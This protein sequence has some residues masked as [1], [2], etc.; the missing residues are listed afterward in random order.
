MSVKPPRNAQRLLLSFLRSD[1]AEEVQGDLEERFYLILKKKSPWRAK[2]NYW[3]QVINYL[4]PFAIRK[5]RLNY[6]NHYDMFQNYFK[7]GFRNLLRNKG[8]SIINIGGLA[9]GMMIAMLIGLWIYDELTYDKYHENYE[10][11]A[12]V[13]Q[14]Q[15]FNGSIYSDYSLPRPLESVLRNEFASD[16]KY[17]SMSSWTGDHI[18]SFGEEKI[19][20]TGNFVQADFP[21]MFSLKMLQGTYKGFQDPTAI[22]LSASTAKALFGNSD[23]LNQSMRIDNRMDVKVVGV[24]QDIPYNSSGN[25]FH[26]LA[27]WDLYANTDDWIKRAV[28][29]WGNNSFQ[30]FVQIAPNATMEGISEKIKNVKRDH[31]K[32]EAAFKPEIY[33][34]PM[35]DW[36]LRS[37]WKEG[38]KTGGRIEMVWLFGIIGIFVLLLACINFM[39]L[40]T[41]RS[42]KRAK[43]VGIR[44]TVGSLRR[45]LINQFLSESFLVVLLA[46]VLTIIFVAL[47]LPAFNNLAD[48]RISIAWLS[49]E[50]WLISILFITVTSL[51]AGSYPAL[52]LSSF[53]PVKVLKGTFKTGRLASIPRKILVVIQFK[54]SVILIIGTIIVYQQIEYTKNRPIGYNRDQLIMMEMK[55][56]EYMGKFDVLKNELKSVGAIEE[57]AESSS[58]ITGVWSNNGGFDWEGKDPALQTDFATIWITHDYGKTV[59]WQLVNGRDMS[60]EFA[61]DSSAIILNEAALKFMNVKE[62]VGM[63]IKWNSRKYHVIG[64]VKDMIMQSPYEPV[65]Q[66]VYV[67]HY[68]NVSWI[69]IKL[70]PEKSA[71]ESLALIESV[72]KKHIP[73]A[74]FEYKFV[75]DEYAKKFDGEVRIGKL[76]LIFAVLAIFISCLGIFGLASFVAEQRTKEIGIRKVMGASVGSLWRMLSKEFV[77]LVIISCAIA[78]P[79][80]YYLLLNWLDKYK[81]HTEISWWII[82]VTGIGTLIITLITVSFQAIKAALMSPVK[83]LKSE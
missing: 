82:V 5:S 53:Q 16:F 20:K 33:L 39:N 65:K 32:D 25:E 62:P 24:Y 26:F 41:A 49:A 18:L 14:H 60:R 31:S 12:Q 10:H 1:L 83:S 71:R 77:L 9:V 69:N 45:Q 57:M 11:I 8:Y 55:S 79:I 36:R 37:E 47:A 66:T 58:P 56:P 50:F 15:T 38:V 29:Q 3:Y 73:S 70:N 64:V 52:Y 80:A 30:M 21:S 68:D 44:M 48:K 67:L 78:I 23:P 2:I 13:M 28:D 51:L 27:N 46:F 35:K 75:D 61:T 74:P 34:H 76:A 4:R 43:E 63:D 7:I 42:E 19:S 59:G 22:L 54:V 72:F 40:S 81:Y 6:S 17:I